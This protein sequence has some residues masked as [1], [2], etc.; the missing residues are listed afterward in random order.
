[1]CSNGISK[2]PRISYKYLRT[3]KQQKIKI[4]RP[5]ISF[6]YFTPIFPARIQEQNQTGG[7]ET[8]KVH[9]LLGVN[10]E[11]VGIMV[12]IMDISGSEEEGFDFGLASTE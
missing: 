9:Y 3:P 8:E 6:L 7:K 12:E 10:H 5:K 4:K 1:M 2:R 11:V